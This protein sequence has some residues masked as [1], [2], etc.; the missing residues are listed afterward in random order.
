[1]HITGQKLDP[2]LFSHPQTSSSKLLD[3]GDHSQDLLPLGMSRG[4]TNNIG[5]GGTLK[6]LV[7]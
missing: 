6:A 4:W 3:I 5:P 7:I 1:M 2:Q